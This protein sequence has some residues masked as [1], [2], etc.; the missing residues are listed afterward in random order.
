MFSSAG[1][2]GVQIHWYIM[3]SPFTYDATRKFFE[4]HKYFLLEADQVRPVLILFSFQVILKFSYLGTYLVHAGHLFPARLFTL[5]FKG[6][7]IH[8]GDSI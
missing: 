7:Q 1:S 8:H 4:T 2:G 5:Y 3:T 6:W